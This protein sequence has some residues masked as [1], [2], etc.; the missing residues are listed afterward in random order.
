MPNPDIMVSTPKV[1]NMP[2]S[3]LEGMNAGLLVIS[4]N[5]GGVPCMISHEINGLLFESNDYKQL[6]ERMLWV[7]KNQDAVKSIINQGHQY[8]KQYSWTVVR[9]KLLALY[10]QND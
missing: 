2:V 3:V 9:D 4:S 6:A 7:G 5:V 8:V 10:K 1:D